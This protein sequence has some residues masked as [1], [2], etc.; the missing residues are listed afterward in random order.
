MMLIVFALA[1]AC[2]SSPETA[3]E[4]GGGADCDGGAGPDPPVCPVHT[5][6]ILRCDEIDPFA[7]PYA[8][9][10]WAACAWTLCPPSFPAPQARDIAT[11]KPAWCL[12]GGPVAWPAP[13]GNHVFVDCCGKPGGDAPPCASATD[14]PVPIGEC[15]ESFCGN[16]GICRITAKAAG[17][18][19]PTG[20]CEGGWG[21]P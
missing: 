18:P 2:T 15:V 12:E 5:P 1:T 6:G 16:D 14:C 8:D 20:H 10:M 11:P 7:M 19:C 17:T 9:R 21:V 4:A 3:V 13:L